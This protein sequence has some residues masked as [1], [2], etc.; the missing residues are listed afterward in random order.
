M[1]AL[2]LEPYCVY[3]TTAA[4]KGHGL[5]LEDSLPSL[6]LDHSLPHTSNDLYENDDDQHAD[7]IIELFKN[8]KVDDVLRKVLTPRNISF[9]TV[10]KR[11]IIL[12]RSM[13]KRNEVQENSLYQNEKYTLNINNSNGIPLS[14]L[15]YL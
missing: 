12:V 8:E 2:G 4:R 5:C 9:E 10:G 13:S 11:Q 14:L 3:L 1:E 15:L 6:L 7:R